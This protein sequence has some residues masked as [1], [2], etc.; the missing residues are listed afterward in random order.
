MLISFVT[1]KFL[2]CHL[3]GHKLSKSEDFK[4]RLQALVLTHTSE[5]VEAE[6]LLLR[7]GNLKDNTSLLR[8]ENRVKFF[9]SEMVQCAI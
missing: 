9:F 2:I 8:L 7:A 3:K 6:I 4:K 5:Q 1:T